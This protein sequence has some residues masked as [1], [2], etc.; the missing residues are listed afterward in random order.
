MVRFIFFG[1]VLSKHKQ[2]QIQQEKVNF[3]HSEGYEGISKCTGT[4]FKSPWPPGS[5]GGQPG[6]EHSHLPAQSF[7]GCWG[8]AANA[9]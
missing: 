7:L 5:W 3:Q 6:T 4:V 1:K 9:E 8:A 2:A